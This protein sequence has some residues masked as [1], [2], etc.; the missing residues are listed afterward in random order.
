MYDNFHIS[1]KQLEFTVVEVSDLKPNEN[2][3]IY[4]FGVVCDGL[5]VVYYIILTVILRTDYALNYSREN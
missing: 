3:R 4:P 1:M 2:L 5:C